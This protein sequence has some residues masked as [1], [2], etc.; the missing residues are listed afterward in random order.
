MEFV[1]EMGARRGAKCLSVCR[2]HNSEIKNHKRLPK[3][4]ISHYTRF[5]PLLLRSLL[6]RSFVSH[7]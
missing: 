7:K 3:G 5:R 6:V 1:S 4:Q 2:E